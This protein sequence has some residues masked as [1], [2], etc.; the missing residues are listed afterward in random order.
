MSCSYFDMLDIRRNPVDACFPGHDRIPA[1]I[2]RDHRR[3]QRNL[4]AHLDLC[5]DGVDIDAA[6]AKQLGDDRIFGSA[7]DW[8]AQGNDVTDEIGALAGKF[9]RQIASEAPTDEVNFL[10]ASSSQGRDPLQY[11]G[12]QLRRIT[13]VSAQA[14]AARAITK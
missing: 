3:G 2:D 7:D 10:V 13:G 11:F 6:T 14:P 1:R 12:Q 9:A 4:V 5:G 8:G